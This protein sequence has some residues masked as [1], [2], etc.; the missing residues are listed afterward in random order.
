LL[1]IIENQYLT[2][3][4]NFISD[5]CHEFPWNIL[6]ASLNTLDGKVHHFSYNYDYLCVDPIRKE[7][8]FKK[9]P[10]QWSNHGHLSAVFKFSKDSFLL[11]T[12]RGVR[13]F[14]A[15]NYTLTLLNTKNKPSYLDTDYG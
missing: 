7:W 11:N 13:I 8:I 15:K 2:N 9:L 12:G 14:D 10:M 4:I 5:T 3:N 6:V 1:K